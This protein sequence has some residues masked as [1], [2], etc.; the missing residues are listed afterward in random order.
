MFK[1]FLIFLRIVW[2]TDRELYLKTK[3]A[4]HRCKMVNIHEK[5]K[6]REFKNSETRYQ[7]EYLHS[8]IM[9]RWYGDKRGED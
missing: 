2:A 9:S 4:E 7:F 8:E 6:D 5:Y 1:E 3:L